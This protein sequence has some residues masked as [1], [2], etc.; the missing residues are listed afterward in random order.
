M[1][2]CMYGYIYVSIYV[3]MYVCMYVFMYVCMYVCKY[4]C[5][6]GYMYVSIY[7]CMYVF[8]YVCKYV[9]MYVRM[10][11]CM[12]VF[13]YV[14]KYVCVCV[15]VCMYSK[16][17]IHPLWG[18][19]SSHAVRWCCVTVHLNIVYCLINMNSVMSSEVRSKSEYYETVFVGRKNHDLEE[20]LIAVESK[21][22]QSLGSWRLEFAKRIFN[23]MGANLHPS[24]GCINS[25]QL[26]RKVQPIDIWK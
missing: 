6:Y 4:V 12:Y 26:C 9:C 23:R 11:V 7:V 5:M 14:S 16:T 19:F 24:S 18:L 17:V 15:Y 20:N 8:M 1:Y 2:V 25:K 22:C 10:Y 13:M 3:C 21:Q